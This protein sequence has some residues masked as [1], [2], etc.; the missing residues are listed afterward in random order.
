MAR[1]VH[2]LP[3]EEA[4]MRRPARPFARSLTDRELTAVAAGVI[5]LPPPPP[6]PPPT[7]VFGGGLSRENFTASQP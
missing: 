6:P 1:E 4:P 5:F 7:G 3:S 2:Q